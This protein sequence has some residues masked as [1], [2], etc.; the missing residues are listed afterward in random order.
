M[1][2]F[3]FVALPAIV[4]FFGA[5]LW[6]SRRPQAV[7]APPEPRAQRTLSFTYQVRVPA[8]P[9]AHGAHLRVP[10]PQSDAFQSISGLQ[11]DSPVHYAEGRDVVYHNFFATFTPST[12]QSAAGYDVTLRFTVTR[13]EHAVNLRAP[14]LVNASAALPVNDPQLKR[15][16]EPDKLVPLNDTIAEL[17]RQ[18]TA[19][20]TTAL[21]K[22]R[23]IYDYVVAT[24]RYDKSGEG[25][26]RGDAVWACSP[27]RGN[28]TD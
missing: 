4:L 22:A 27:K 9:D 11:I 21:Q 13:S 24:M 14:A 12:A 1:R 8:D 16:L 18:Q 17:A 20:E 23:S 19:G 15:Y 5:L 25:W 7:A 10:L 2:N 6:F 3:R 28:C 26:G